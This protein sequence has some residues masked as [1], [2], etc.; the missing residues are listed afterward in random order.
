MRAERINSRFMGEMAMGLVLS[1]VSGLVVAIVLAGLVLTL[2][3][4]VYAG[5]VA[6][7]GNS[8]LIEKKPV[9]RH[10]LS[11]PVFIRSGAATATG[12]TAY[13][14][15]Y[16]VNEASESVVNSSRDTQYGKRSHSSSRLEIPVIQKFFLG[17]V[18]LGLAILLQQH[19]KSRS[20]TER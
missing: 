19:W 16:V 1:V 5:A 8:S 4:P 9:S 20:I 15:V 11:L 12:N 18:L 17:L 2:P 6:D 3:A 13:K 7:A 10:G 14:P